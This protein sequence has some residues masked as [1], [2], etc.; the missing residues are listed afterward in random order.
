[1]IRKESFFTSKI[2]IAIIFTAIFSLI[3][4]FNYLYPL[5]QDDGVYLY[6]WD[7][8]QPIRNIYDILVSQYKH[9]I[10]WG[11]RVVV[12]TI[13]QLLLLVG[14]PIASFLNTVAFVLLI[15]MMYKIANIGQKS[16]WVL[17]L[18]IFLAIWLFQGHLPNTVFWITGS[19]NYLWGT[20]IILLFIHKYVKYF[21]FYYKK[22]GINNEKRLINMLT[23]ILF[24]FFGILAGWTNENMAVALVPCLILIMAYLKYTYSGKLPLWMYAGLMGAAIG[25]LLLILA[26][27]NFVRLG[28]RSDILP[29]SIRLE[30]AWSSANK[31][32]LFSTIVFIVYG[33][34]K[35]ACTKQILVV[36]L[37]T[38][39]HH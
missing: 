24:F 28:L 25:T 34:V 10:E 4:Y 30:E 39:V 13:A 27:G 22:V 3:G 18:L 7:E 17:L 23:A 12:H 6:I 14:K 19:A 16:N 9:Y 37:Q 38:N 15:Y 26:P 1:M 21:L 31:I 8:D 29:V 20:L 5:W 11:G 36:Y 2:A 32:L 35:K 33:W